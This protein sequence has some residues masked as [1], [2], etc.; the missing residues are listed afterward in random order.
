M[1]TRNSATQVAPVPGT[2]LHVGSLQPRLHR[3]GWA[4]SAR[5]SDDGFCDTAA[6]INLSVSLQMGLSAGARTLSFRGLAELGL[7]TRLAWDISADNLIAAAAHPAGT[8]FYLRDAE[9]TTAITASALQIRVPG[10]P[11]TAWLAHPRTFTILHR[12]VEKQLGA[13]VTYFAPLEDV[14][15]AVASD[16]PELE[17]FGKWAQATMSE[18]T[19]TGERISAAP[20]RYRLGFPTDLGAARNLV[21]AR[22]A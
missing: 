11:V 7:G 12:H 21:P 3:Q 18:H 17:N 4:E 2:G 8:R 10:A 5:L 14:L 13:E 19:N 1:K 22:A 16:S 15:L 20:L 9:A 6:S